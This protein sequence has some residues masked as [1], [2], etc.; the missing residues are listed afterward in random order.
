KMLHWQDLAT[1]VTP[2]EQVF[3]VSHYGTPTVDLDHWELRVQGLV[4]SPR[5][6][7]LRELKARKRKSV[8]ALLECS[9]NSS[10]PRFIGAVGSMRWTGTPLAPLLRECGIQSRAIEVVFFGADEKVEKIR[11]KEYPQNFGRSLSRTD[12][13]R[14]E[15]LLAYEMNGE[16]LSKEHGGPLR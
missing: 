1:W 10:N 12:A 4:R 16:P 15:V 5:T 13:V 9:G 11:E 14:D 8:V 3:A 6:F 2:N 7:T